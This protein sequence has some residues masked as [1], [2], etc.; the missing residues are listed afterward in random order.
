MTTKQWLITAV[1]CIIV[2]ILPPPTQFFF[3]CLAFGALA[4]AI[5]SAFTTISWLPWVVFSVTTVAL[6]PL[7]V[8]LARFLFTPRQHPSNV[9]ELIGQTG[10]VVDQITEQEGGKVRVGN[11][12]WR[13]RGAGDVI[14]KDTRVQV[15]RVEGTFLIVRRAT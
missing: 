4:A 12:V 3:L 7:L 11:D 9:D 8:P 10:V 14:P 13:A 1:V 6:T 2:E 5:A 15:E